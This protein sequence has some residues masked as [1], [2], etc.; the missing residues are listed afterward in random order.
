LNPAPLAQ[1][2]AVGALVVAVAF[3]VAV[4][5]AVALHLQT[6]QAKTR[7][8]LKAPEKML[9]QQEPSLVLMGWMRHVL[10]ALHRQKWLDLLAHT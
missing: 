2:L 6:Y 3:A 7:E 1:G 5:A 4:P 10:P 8:L 9:L